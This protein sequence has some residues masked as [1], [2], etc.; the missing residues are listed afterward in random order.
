MMLRNCRILLIAASIML[1]I[2]SCKKDYTCTCFDVNGV[3]I[4]AADIVGATEDDAN[5]LCDGSITVGA[6]NG[7]TCSLAER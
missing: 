1:F 3:Y 2:T 5:A 7:A 6:G 4:I